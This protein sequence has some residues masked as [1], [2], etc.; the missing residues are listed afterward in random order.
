[1]ATGSIPFDSWGQYADALKKGKRDRAQDLARGGTGRLRTLEALIEGKTIASRVSFPV[2]DVPARMVAGTVSEA[3]AIGFSPA[4]LPLTEPRSEFAS[5]WVHLCEAHMAEGFH[6]PVKLVEYLGRFYAE[7]GNKRVSVLKYYHVHSVRAEIVRFVPEY[8]ASDPEV[9]LYYDFMEFHRRTGMYS[10]QLTTPG[11]YTELYDLLSANLKD[12]SAEGFRHFEAAEFEA[13]RRVLHSSAGIDPLYS[14]GDILLAYLRLFGMPELDDEETVAGR[15]RLLGEELL[16]RRTADTEC[17]SVEPEKKVP[18]SSGGFLGSLLGSPRPLRVGFLYARTPDSSLWTRA[19]E[20]GRLQAVAALGSRIE[21]TC[22]Y[23]VPEGPGAAEAILEFACHGFD[24]IFATTPAMLAPTLRASLDLPEVRFFCCSEAHPYKHVETYFGRMFE[25]R[26]LLGMVAGSLSRSGRL[27]CVATWPVPDVVS[28]LNAFT[29]GARMV[30]PSVEVLVEWTRDWESHA[31]SGMLDEERRLLAA[32]ADPISRQYNLSGRGLVAGKWLSEAE[33]SGTELQSL[34][35]PRWNWGVFYERILKD[36][37]DQGPAT[38]YDR[39][40]VRSSA[41]AFWWGIGSGLVDLVLDET[42]V[43]DPTRRLVHWMRSLL[44][45][46]RLHPFT[47]PV[48]DNEGNLRI[49]AGETPG[50]ETISRMDW[51]VEGIRTEAPVMEQEQAED[52]TR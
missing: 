30:N 19:H 32:G 35:A 38:P 33:P 49:T 25:A 36:L 41:T 45:E 26:F 47:G 39:F 16:T 11:R 46:G 5:K 15:L 4:F 21:T 14:S 29:L 51:F 44:V 7:E 20:D 48:T 24:A 2:R 6:Q 13:F 31:R 17:V 27:G 40:L 9:V 12:A 23:D 37:M 28:G 3:R 8:D 18:P 52:V 1:M 42:R 43:P 50:F 22:L 10:V 34:A